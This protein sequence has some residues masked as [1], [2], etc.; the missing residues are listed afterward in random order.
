MSA[1]ITDLALETAASRIGV[2][3]IF[4]LDGRE[5]HV[6]GL[7]GW[8]PPLIAKWW[9]GKEVTII[10]VDVDG[11]FFLRH[12]DGSVGFWEHSKKSEMVVAESVKEFCSR[13]REDTNGSLSWWRSRGSAD[14][15]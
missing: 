3:P 2:K 5:I 6:V 1:P 12:S 14:A 13:L 10:G 7:F 11:N 9:R 8:S 4:E 15:T